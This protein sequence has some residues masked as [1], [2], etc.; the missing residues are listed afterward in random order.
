MDKRILLLG[1]TGK[2]GTALNTVLGEDYAISCKNSKDFDAM[3]FDSVRDMIEKE[4]P[5]IVINTVAFL[6]IDPCELEP[7]RAF[8]MNTLYP[9]QLAELS[10]EKSFVLVH[11]STDAVFSDIDPGACYTEDDTPCPLNVYGLTKY[12]GDCFI[13]CE[14]RQHYIFRI[15]VQFGE[16]SKTSQFVEK[17]LLMVNNG[18]KELC[19]SDDIISSPTYSYDVA[20]EV[21]R[22]IEGDYP[23]GLYHI[24]NEGPGTLYELMREI[25]EVMGLD[26]EIK[27]A[28]YKDFPCIGRKNLCTPMTSLKL[29]NLRHWKE[30]VRDY[31]KEGELK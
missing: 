13:Q 14:T 12:G 1:S 10:S 21:K 23:F 22:V 19:I 31:C 18:K 6:G 15:S 20:H 4:K 24:A 8:K 11:F 30:A 28:S 27:K 2:V 9:K 29:D 17:M 7:E 16:T 3:N 26:V 25:V 5:E